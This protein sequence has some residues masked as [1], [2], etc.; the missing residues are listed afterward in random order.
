[1]VSRAAGAAGPVLLACRQWETHGLTRRPPSRCAA[2]LHCVLLLPWRVH[3]LG[4][5]C[6]ALT[7][8]LE[9]GGQCPF[10]RL[11]FG[12]LPALAFLAVR[13]AGC[14]PCWDTPGWALPG[15][16]RSGSPLGPR[17]VSVRAS[18]PLRVGVARALRAVPVQGT[19]RTLPAGLC[20]SAFPPALPCSDYLALGAVARS[21]RPLALLGVTRPP[22]GRPA[23]VLL[24][25]CWASGVGCSP[26]PD[27][28]SFGACGRGP[29]PTGCWCGECGRG[30]PSP[31][32]LRP[33]LRAG[34]A[35]CGGDTRAPGGGTSC[36]CAGRPGSGALPPPTARHF[37]GAAGADYPLAVGAGRV[38]VG[39]RHQPYSAR[40]CELAL[41]A[42]GAP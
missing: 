37:G 32:P 21:I 31:I 9:G 12:L 24:C 11:P 35:R 28:P 38:G 40:S 13:V 3:R 30:K 25:G 4:R 20:P 22:A 41:P 27:C 5:V 39:T 7:A 19:G 34:F 17:H 26:T 14:P 16:S 33:L 23:F 15:W 42:F 2:V 10:L 36:L 1:M 6:A 29:L 18:P 8:G